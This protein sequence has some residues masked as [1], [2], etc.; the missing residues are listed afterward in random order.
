MLKKNC[1]AI[2]DMNKRDNIKGK[3]HFEKVENVINFLTGDDL[4]K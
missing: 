1:M 3:L 2:L 4:L